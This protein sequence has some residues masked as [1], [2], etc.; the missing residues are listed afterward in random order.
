[1]ALALD[2]DAAHQLMAQAG[3]ARGRRGEHATEAH[4]RRLQARREQARIGLQA[5]GLPGHQ[6]QGLRVGAVHVQV[7]AALLD[8][9]DLAAQAQASYNSAPLSS[10]K[11]GRPR[12]VRS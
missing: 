5:A 2:Q 7:K 1:M 11:G 4:I 10:A 6:V 3:A 8:H 9:E 12:S